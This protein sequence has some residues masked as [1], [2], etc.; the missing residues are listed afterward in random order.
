[1]ITDFLQGVVLGFGAA[2]PL[3][4]INILIMNEALKFYKNGVAVGVGAM[5]ADTTYLLI[6]LFGLTYYINNETVLAWLAYL[7]AIFLLYMAYLIY[8]NR[9]RSIKRIQTDTK[10]SLIKHYI[11][12]YA[13]TLLSPYTIIFW[14]SVSTFSVQSRYPLVVV[15]GMLFAIL[16]WITVMPYFIHKTKHLIS[17]TLYSKVAV[18]SA[19]IMAFFAVSMVVHEVFKN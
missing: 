2:V 8:K 14:I 4:P 6:I 10:G 17:N 3:G 15:C 11:K 12:G 1:M 16:V 19:L 9:D 18:I 7:G 13:L 5:S